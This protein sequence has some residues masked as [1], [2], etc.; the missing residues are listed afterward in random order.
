[1]GRSRVQRGKQVET[2]GEAGETQ[3]QGQAWRPWRSV[4]NINQHPS[5]CY[6]PKN[7]GHQRTQSFLLQDREQM[8]RKKI[9]W[10]KVER[11]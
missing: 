4:W 5:F 7:L 8:R 3:S 2:R 6:D 9:R 1:M 11:V 10:G